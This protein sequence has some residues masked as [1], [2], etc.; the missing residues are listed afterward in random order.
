[1]SVPNRVSL[2]K[3]SYLV[4]RTRPLKIG[5]GGVLSCV[6]YG[7]FTEERKRETARE[8]Q[9]RKTHLFRS[10]LAHVALAVHAEVAVEAG[11]PAAAKRDVPPVARD[12]DVDER[13]RPRQLVRP[14]KR[15]CDAQ[16]WGIRTYTRSHA[17]GPGGIL[18]GVTFKHCPHTSQTGAKP[19]E[20]LRKGISSAA[21]QKREPFQNIGHTYI[22]KT[23]T[24][25]E[26]WGAARAQHDVPERCIEVKNNVRVADS[27]KKQDKGG[28]KELPPPRPGKA[29]Q[30]TTH[31][32]LYV[33]L[34]RPQFGKERLGVGLNSGRKCCIA[35]VTLRIREKGSHRKIACCIM[36]LRERAKQA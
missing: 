22:S 4:Q 17:G 32:S 35:S 16:V 10:G 23:H 34:P 6:T 28:A 24:R 12:V 36:Q 5:P 31:H 29:N 30:G 3:E 21:C 9:E 8:T 20:R 13:V 1:M 25:W 7:R 26:A 15:F 19:G 11:G 27:R 18:K 33:S 2:E 14:R